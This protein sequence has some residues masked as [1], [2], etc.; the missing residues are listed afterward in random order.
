MTDSHGSSLKGLTILAGLALGAFAVGA[1]IGYIDGSSGDDGSG[2][3]G[4]NWAIRTGF[5]LL[6]MMVSISILGTV[7]FS[8]LDL[9][10]MIGWAM[11]F[12][13]GFAIMN[14]G[15]VILGMNDKDFVSQTVSGLLF[16][17]IIGAIAGPI[18]QRNQSRRAQQSD[19][20]S[21]AETK[22]TT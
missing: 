2:D 5:L 15:G 21:N 17:G 22:Q 4:L 7:M 12:G 6:G 13:L 8:K 19:T 10:P 9:P 16:G 1:I 3:R 20:E 18:I 11:I 14:G